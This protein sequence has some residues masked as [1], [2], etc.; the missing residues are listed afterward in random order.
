MT[1]ANTV[2]C[3]L[4]AACASSAAACASY[5]LF[6]NSSQVVRIRGVPT[7]QVLCQLI[8]ID[9]FLIV[10]KVVELKTYYTLSLP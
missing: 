2:R 9:V 1:I 10:L 6:V 5:Y 7:A 4:A 3:F 8:E